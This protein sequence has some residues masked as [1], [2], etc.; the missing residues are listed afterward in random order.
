MIKAIIPA[1]FAI[2]C[3]APTQAACT[4]ADLAGKWTA[5]VFT[6]DDTGKLAWIACTMVINAQGEFQTGTSFCKA[7]GQTQQVHGALRTQSAPMCLFAG[8]I[9]TGQGAANSI[10]SLTL[11]LDKQSAT[12]AAGK[13]GSR[14]VSMFSMMKVK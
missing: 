11:S 3:A 10:P 7:S 8:T 1:V 4:Q 13:N 9:T 12:G 6:Q 14:N 2:A 5:Y